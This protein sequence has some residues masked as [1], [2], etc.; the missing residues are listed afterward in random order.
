MIKFYREHNG[1]FLCVD[2]GSTHPDPNMLEGRAAAIEGLASSVCTT[3]MSKEFLHR[4]CR[5]VGK[6]EVPQA[7]LDAMLG[8]GEVVWT[9]AMV[10]EKLP[11][12]RVKVGKKIVVGRVTGRLNAFATV[13]IQLEAGERLHRGNRP[14]ADAAF[15]WETLVDCLNDGRPLQW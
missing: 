8:P 14:W 2:T 7:W 13:T 10:K 6:G 4:K 1:D 3:S 12:V 15:A 5:R 9:V 11:D